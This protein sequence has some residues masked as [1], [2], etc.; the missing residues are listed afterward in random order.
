MEITKPLHKQAFSKL[1]HNSSYSND[2]TTHR[3]S[4]KSETL[5]CMHGKIV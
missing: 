4:Y 5:N 2:E 1:N 3:L